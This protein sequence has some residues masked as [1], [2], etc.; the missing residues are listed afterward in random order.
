M[1]L[2]WNCH[3]VD[4]RPWFG[5]Y[6]NRTEPDVNVNVCEC[7]CLCVYLVSVCVVLGSDRVV[8]LVSRTDPSYA[9]NHSLV[10]GWWRDQG[11]NLSGADCPTGRHPTAVI[12]SILLPST[13]TILL[14]STTI[15]I[16]DPTQ[17]PHTPRSLAK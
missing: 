10:A 4:N 16:V 6:V 17:S 8:F 3:R 15:I 13:T 1:N 14:P 7:L 2:L 11:T 5:W 12:P 9:H